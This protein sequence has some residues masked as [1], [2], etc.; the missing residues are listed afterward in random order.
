[1]DSVPVY[2]ATYSYDLV[3]NRLEMSLSNASGATTTEHQYDS[4]DRLLRE[5]SDDGRVLTYT[6]DADGSL[7]EKA[8]NGVVTERFA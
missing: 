5:E 2:T 4:D 1:M 6:Y 3:G 8:M 7:V